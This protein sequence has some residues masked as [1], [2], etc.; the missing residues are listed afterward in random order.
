MG[1]TPTSEVFDGSAL[2]PIWARLDA[3][4]KAMDEADRWFKRSQ[5]LSDRR[6]DGAHRAGRR[7]YIIANALIAK[8]RESQLMLA[9]TMTTPGVNVFP[10]AT[11]DIIRPA[12]E[13]AAAAL[14]ILDGDTTEDRRLRGLRCA[15]KDHNES[16]KWA[17]E[18]M[19]PMFMT[20]EQIAAQQAKHATISKRYIDDARDLGLNW[21]KVTNA[22]N[23][24]HEVG[25]FS[26]VGSEPELAAF[27]RAIWRRLSGVQHGLMY[28]GLLGSDMHQAVPIPGGVEVVLFTNDD[29]LMTDCQ[30]SALMQLW[31]MGRYIE[32]TRYLSR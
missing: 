19:L 10:H 32:R 25:K 31:A 8:A 11:P 20:D 7:A 16:R 4:E 21:G 22:M 6:L 9:Q 12:F 3:T 18:L 17:Q 24:R 1:R 29:S 23:V 26:T 28:A 2:L 14:W 5:V 30:A 15:W 27:L 13:A